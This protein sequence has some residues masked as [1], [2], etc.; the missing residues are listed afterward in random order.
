VYQGE[1]LGMTN[2]PFTSLDQLV[3]I[4]GINFARQARATGH[5]DTEILAGIRA[6]G[7][8]NARTPMQWDAGAQAGF[9]TG[10]PWLPVNPNHTV[11]NAAAQVDDPDSVFTHYQRLIR[12]RHAEPAVTLGDFT[13]LLDD[14][15]QVYAFTR[16]HADTELLVMVNVSSDE[17]HAPLADGNVWSRADVVLGEPYRPTMAPWEQRVLKRAVD[18]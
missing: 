8:D 2:Y 1:E 5:A 7:R 13:M 18:G 4:E 17:A 15:R 6:H 12:L 14:H 11:I 10:A 3:D 9:T 16:R